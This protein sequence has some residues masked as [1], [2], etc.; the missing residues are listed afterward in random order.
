MA[1][2]ISDPLPSWMI[3]PPLNI[4]CREVHASYS[5][6]HSIISGNPTFV[7]KIAVLNSQLKDAVSI[8]LGKPE[9]WPKNTTDFDVTCVSAQVNSDTGRYTTDADGEMINYN[10]YVLLDLVYMA[11][12]GNYLEDKNNQDVFW[13]DEEEPRVESNVMNHRLLI[14]GNTTDTVP[15]DKIQLHA[16]EAPSIYKNG[17]NLIHTIEGF[18]LDFTDLD[19]LIGT[20]NDD[21][22]LS[23]TINKAFIV[24]SML[25]DDYKI[26]NGYNFKSYRSGAMSTTLKLYYKYKQ[27]GWN[28][29]WRHGLENVPEGY[30]Y[31]RRNFDP[32]PRFDP[33]PLADHSK[34]LEWI[35]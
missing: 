34:Y 3:S 17:T 29:F 13:N 10:Q 33:F 26:L 21:I 14:W 24:G 31:I 16:D 23:P 9:E 1:K 22:Y 15:N 28:K 30:Y 18:E 20:C 7:A 25:L 4:P 35:P 11:R 19:D 6:S 32:W 12:V 8:L 27:I 2:W 5:E